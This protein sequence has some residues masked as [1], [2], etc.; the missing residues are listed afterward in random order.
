MMKNETKKYYINNKIIQKKKKFQATLT[1]FL[2]LGVINQT[3]KYFKHNR[4]T[5]LHI[6]NLQTCN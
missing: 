3:F 1:E 5:D 6:G 4:F 2:E